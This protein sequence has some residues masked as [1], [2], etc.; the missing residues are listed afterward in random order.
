MQFMPMHVRAKMYEA[1]GVLTR[2]GYQATEAQTEISLDE[3]AGDL[4]DPRS[5]SP[6]VAADIWDTIVRHCSPYE[7]RLVSL[8]AGLRNYR[9]IGEVVG[10]SDETVRLDMEWIRWK[11]EPDLCGAIHN[12]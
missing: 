8:R 7:Q 9:E 10:R 11:V 12:P 3:F 6:T 4:P 1:Y 2:R 5:P